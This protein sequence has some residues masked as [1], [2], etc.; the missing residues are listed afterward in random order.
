MLKYESIGILEA[1]LALAKY[2]LTDYLK[3]LSFSE[4]ENLK[5]RLECN[6]LME[7]AITIYD[8]IMQEITYRFMDDYF[9]LRSN[10]VLGKDDVTDINNLNK[11]VS[12]YELLNS[13]G[14][15]QKI[16]TYWP[17]LRYFDET[18]ACYA[19]LRE[20]GKSMDE[21]FDF[22]LSENDEVKNVSDKTDKNLMLKYSRE[23]E[24]LIFS[25]VDEIKSEKEAKMSL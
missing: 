22:L 14:D 19:L 20:T 18:L 2:N 8:A 5:V 23:F 16:I 1:K 17:A 15:Y 9:Y 12:S 25:I 24:S 11:L 10:G 6:D 7:E 13:F 3:S 21:V 4:L